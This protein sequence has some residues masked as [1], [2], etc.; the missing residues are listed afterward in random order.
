[1]IKIK[2][3]G[4]TLIE[5]LIVVVIIGVLAA[6][7][8]PNYIEQVNK[9]RRADAQAA[10][11]ELAARLQEYYIDQ[12]PTPTFAGASLIGDDAI[13]P[14]TV[15]LESDDADKYYDLEFTTPP[16]S[17]FF[18]IEAKPV[19]TMTGDFT[20]SLDSRGSKQHSKGNSSPTDGWP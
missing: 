2:K 19:G 10:L 18:K 17:T 1:M 4:F 13:F 8:Y 15:P 3:T 11:V 6:I 7:A 12:T 5:V 16:T 14:N 20:F 9:A